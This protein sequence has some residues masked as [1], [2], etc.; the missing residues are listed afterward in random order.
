MNILL[1]GVGSVGCEVCVELREIGFTKLIIVDPDI[2][3]LCNLNRQSLYDK[4][5]KGRPKVDVAK[6]YFKGQNVDVY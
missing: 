5:A 1:V 2:V 6:A 4:E 3:E